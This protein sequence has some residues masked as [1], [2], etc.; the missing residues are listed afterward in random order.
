[1]PIVLGR[2]DGRQ[3]A[4]GWKTFGSDAMTRRVAKITVVEAK[5]HIEGEGT[6]QRS[7]GSDP[8]IV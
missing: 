1:M 4:K 2:E 8:L 7:T 6:Y 3:T 5:E